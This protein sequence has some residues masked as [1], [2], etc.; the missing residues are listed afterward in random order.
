MSVDEKN[1]APNFQKDFLW[2]FLGSIAPMLLGFIKT[3]IFTRHFNRASFGQLGLVSITYIFLGMLLFSWISS[4][5][6][7]YYSR[8]KASGRL[9]ILY[10]NLLLLYVLSVGLLGLISLIWFFTSETA[11]TRQLIVYSFLQLILNQLFLAY[12]VVVRLMG[13]SRFYNIFQGFRAFVGLSIALIM[14]F[15]F[16]IGIVALVSSLVITDLLCLMFLS[17]ANPAKLKVNVKDIKVEVLKELFHYGSMGLILNISLLSLSYSDRYII[18]FFYTLEEVG[19]YDQVSKI[20]QLSVMSLITIYFNTIS[21][22]LIKQLESNFKNSLVY[23][24]NYLWIFIVIGLPIVCYF[25]FFSKEIASILLGKAFREGY[26]LMPFIFLATYLHGLSNFFELRLKF[27]DKLVR[28][29]VIA[30]STAL[31]N[32]VLN[33]ILIGSFGYHWAATT[34]FVSY[35]FMVFILFS[36]DKKV[37]GILWKKRGS[38]FRIVALLTIQ[39]A[40]Y[41]F[42]VDKMNLHLGVRIVIGFIFALT[43]FV[44]FRKSILTLKVT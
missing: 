38:M 14:V 15:Y 43:Y 9:Q 44:L 17:Y 33:F 19:I 7:R 24:Q 25:A 30:L 39:Y 37:L 16:T 32:I 21:P 31:L 28:L 2:Y 27:R 20:A 29:A 5:L 6:W 12:M 11:L 3:P 1:I 42:F 26:V 8:Y 22:S 18:A 34:T 13:K 10:S 36:G 40:F 4:C 35:L 41:Y 23:I